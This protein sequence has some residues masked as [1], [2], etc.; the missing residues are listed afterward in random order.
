MLE[1]GLCDLLSL[2]DGKGR[3]L[4]G[5]SKDDHPIGA[6]ILEVGHHVFV[7]AVVELEALVAGCARRDVELALVAAGGRRSFRPARSS[8]GSGRGC[9]G[10]EKRSSSGMHGVRSL[11]RE[12]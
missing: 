7:H 11:H 12:L 9:N 5:R 1:S 3:I 6:L 2:G 10:S 8:R 4:T